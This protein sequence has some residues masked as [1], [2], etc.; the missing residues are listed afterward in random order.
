MASHAPTEVAWARRERLDVGVWTPNAR[1]AA[2]APSACTRS[3]RPVLRPSRGS[4]AMG[5]TGPAAVLVRLPGAARRA[6]AF[7][8][9][10]AQAAAPS[11]RRSC[12]R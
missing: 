6:C 9:A 1:G 12:V 11:G 3:Q 7:L 10:P 4:T 8:R 2:H 5:D